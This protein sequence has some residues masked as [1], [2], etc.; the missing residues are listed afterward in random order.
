MSVYIHHLLYRNYCISHFLCVGLVQL[1][2]ISQIHYTKNVISH[3]NNSHTTH[4][5]LIRIEKSCKWNGVKILIT[6]QVINNL[7]APRW[8]K[9]LSEW[10]VYQK[11]S[12]VN[13]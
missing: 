12:C 8:P 13:D 11:W 10:A 3:N 6:L 7:L 4:T 1:Q 5:I 2:L 9:M